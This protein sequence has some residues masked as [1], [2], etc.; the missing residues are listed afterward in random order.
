MATP[1]PLQKTKRI[2]FMWNCTVLLRGS[3]D[4]PFMGMT[5]FQASVIQIVRLK[6]EDRQM[7]NFGTN[8]R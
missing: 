5:G 3:H 7:R 6:Q 1:L 2:L 4:L 8:R